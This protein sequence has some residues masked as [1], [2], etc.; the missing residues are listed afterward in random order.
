MNEDGE[1]ASGIRWEGFPKDVGPRKQRM[2][3]YIVLRFCEKRDQK[4]K[5]LFSAMELRIAG[6][7][8]QGRKDAG[9]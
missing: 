6:D 4:H 3:C 9:R 1:E 8:R 7:Y 2:K 5:I